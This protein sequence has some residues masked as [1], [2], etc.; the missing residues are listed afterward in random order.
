MPFSTSSTQWHIVLLVD[1][2]PYITRCQILSWEQLKED[3]FPLLLASASLPPPHVFLV[4]CYGLSELLHFCSVADAIGHDV[5]IPSPCFRVSQ[6]L[7]WKAV[8]AQ[9][10]ILHVLSIQRPGWCISHFR[11][12]FLWLAW[13]LWQLPCVRQLPAAFLLDS[14]SASD[15]NS[16]NVTLPLEVGR[17]NGYQLDWLW[18]SCLASYLLMLRSPQTPDNK[19]VVD[20][21]PC[22]RSIM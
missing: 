8:K 11:T 9:V 7:C 5:I 20:L 6:C 3:W 12:T 1:T 4:C 19:C 17:A 18:G 13:M 2:T 21:T 15:F 16:T 10:H 14:L 22:S